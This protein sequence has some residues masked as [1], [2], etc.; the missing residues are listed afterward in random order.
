MLFSENSPF[1][2]FQYSLHYR[3]GTFCNLVCALDFFQ[4]DERGKKPF[5][6]T[7]EPPVDSRSELENV[8]RLDAGVLNLKHISMALLMLLISTAVYFLQQHEC[9]F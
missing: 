9:P 8:R 5:T 7:V 6:E 1:H 4:L 3:N 2:Y